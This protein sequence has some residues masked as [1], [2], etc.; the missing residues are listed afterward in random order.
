VDNVVKY[1][2]FLNFLDEAFQSA[3]SDGSVTVEILSTQDPSS[4]HFQVPNTGDTTSS[5]A[6]AAN[7]GPLQQI[8]LRCYVQDDLEEVDSIP[9][10][11]TWNQVLSWLSISLF[12]I[13]HA[14]RVPVPFTNLLVLVSSAL[15]WHHTDWIFHRAVIQ[16]Q[17]DL[18]EYLGGLVHLVFEDK[19]GNAVTV[20]ADVGWQSLVKLVQVKPRTC[21]VVC[22]RH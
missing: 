16:V 1:T 19:D 18:Q 17:K 2:E 3:G 9:V 13:S 5:T 7:S 21:L 14:I 22:L 8:C 4:S 20:D 10:E 6:V 12:I 15:Y 11:W